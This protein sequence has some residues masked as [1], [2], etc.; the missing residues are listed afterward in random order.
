[1]FEVGGNGRLLLLAGC[2]NVRK[3]CPA[4][5]DLLVSVHDTA[6]PLL[7][8]LRGPRKHG[9]AL[10]QGSTEVSKVLKCAGLMFYR[11][12]WGCPKHKCDGVSRVIERSVVGLLG[13]GQ[14]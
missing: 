7:E 3:P 9:S 11:H 5:A 14:V 10:L 12:Q 1:M 13:S 6:R 8:I 4:K 2:C